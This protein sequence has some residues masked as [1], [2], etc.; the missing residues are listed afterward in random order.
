LHIH[1]CLWRIKD[2]G[3]SRNNVLEMFLLAI[4]LA[5]AAIPEGLVA[6]VTIVLS[7]GVTKC[8]NAMR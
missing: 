4:S 6:V 7:I 2:G 1:I 8:P 3:F 5:V